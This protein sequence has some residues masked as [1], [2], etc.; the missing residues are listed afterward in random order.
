M[1]SEFA[2][3]F[4]LVTR[5]YVSKDSDFSE[6][7]LVKK[8]DINYNDFIWFGYLRDLDSREQQQ[9]IVAS[10]FGGPITGATNVSG[11]GT[12]SAKLE[13]DPVQE[14]DPTGGSIY[15]NCASH[16]GIM[17][18]YSESGQSTIHLYCIK[19][20]P[21]Y[22]SYTNKTTAYF[23]DGVNE[24]NIT[25]KIVFDGNY[26]EG[27]GPFLWNY[28][29]ITNNL[30]DT[31]TQQN[32]WFLCFN[33][34]DT[35]SEASRLTNGGNW[36]CDLYI[37]NPN[38]TLLKKSYEIQTLDLP[39]VYKPF[40]MRSRIVISND[41]NSSGN[42]NYKMF[43]NVYN[44]IGFYENNVYNIASFSCSINDEKITK[45][46]TSS[47]PT[48]LSSYDESV[49][50]IY[51]TGT[52][53]DLNNINIVYGIKEAELPEGYSYTPFF[54]NSINYNKTVSFGTIRYSYYQDVDKNYHITLNSN[55]YN[56][57]SSGVRYFFVS[58]ELYDVITG[59]TECNTRQI[60]ELMPEQSK[61]GN[62]YNQF[63]SLYSALYF[64]SHNEYIYTKLDENAPKAQAILIA[65]KSMIGDYEFKNKERPW[66]IIGITDPLIDLLVEDENLFMKEHEAGGVLS[67]HQDFVSIITYK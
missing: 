67:P 25:G 47:T 8:D 54:R 14:L 4:H 43:T 18:K 59:N 30:L 49:H 65:T 27:E 11:S 29:S 62:G 48:L 51:G 1:A 6:L 66:R 41:N 9:V 37:V 50:S 38:T 53:S 12:F 39:S 16:T 26:I 40:Y 58:P 31:P 22:N 24:N 46:I 19:G 64:S 63:L 56:T 61:Y 57:S 13:W 52:T 44:G 20:T 28:E 3:Y 36:G 35:L 10:G 33:G 60:F 55:P 5:V 45:T 34:S 7:A 21:S 23:Y 42:Y 15:G 17:F 32:L 2:Q